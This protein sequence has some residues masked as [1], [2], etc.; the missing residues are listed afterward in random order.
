MVVE[1]RKLAEDETGAWVVVSADDDPSIYLG[2]APS[3]VAHAAA[4]LLRPECL[5]IGPPADD[6]QRQ[7]QQYF[8]EMLPGLIERQK[9]P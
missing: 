9:A 6:L 3:S 7:A 4:W 5:I 8:L 2:F 1:I